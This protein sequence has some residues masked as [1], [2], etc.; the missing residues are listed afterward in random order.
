MKYFFLLLIAF[1]FSNCSSNNE[2]YWCGDHACVNKKEKEFYF[3]EKMIVEKRLVKKEE[4]LSKD[5]KDEIMKMIREKE[6]SK[7]KKRKE[8]NEEILISK[9][10]TGKTDKL[11][12]SSNQAVFTKKEC[13]SWDMKKRSLKECFKFQSSKEKIKSEDKSILSTDNVKSSSEFNELV[14]KITKENMS[15]PYPDIN[16]IQN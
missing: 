10:V 15:K 8:K 2:V 12:P 3:K 7:S 5:K 9:K 1:L 4:K 6:K 11:E 14:E 13:L 16:N